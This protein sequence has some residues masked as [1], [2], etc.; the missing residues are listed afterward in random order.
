MNIN[1]IICS[2]VS[3]NNKKRVF[4]ILDYRLKKFV[5]FNKMNGL[6]YDNLYLSD[7]KYVIKTPLPDS[8]KKIFR[9]N[10]R[11]EEFNLTNSI[12]IYNYD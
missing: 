5:D 4:R 2:K 8:S 6:F 1:N 11:I 7:I 3:K 9:D 12:F 10:I